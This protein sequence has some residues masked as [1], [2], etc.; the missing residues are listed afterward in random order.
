MMVQFASNLIQ[1]LK[2]F[3]DNLGPQYVLP[4]ELPESG[5]HPSIVCYVDHESFL[6]EQYKSMCVK[7]NGLSTRSKHIKTCLIT[8]CQPEEGKTTTC[9]NVAYSFAA[10]NKLSTVLID[11]DLRRP[12]IH[13]LW[14]IAEAPGLTDYLNGDIALDQLLAAPFVDGLHIIPAG[15]PV[16]DPSSLLSSPLLEEM[17][18]TLR[19]KYDRVIVDAPPV[20]RAADASTIGKLCDAVIF[21]V[22]AGA[23]PAN[24]IEEAFGV[25]AGTPAAPKA[26]ILTCASSSPDYFSYLTNQHYRRHF[27]GKYASYRKHY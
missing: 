22:R 7:I 6:N 20:L 11:A 5:V 24:M 12:K 9:C 1:G 27:Y 13:E 23:T 18:R 3:W 4:N 26:C 19:R 10:V 15:S 17:F 21:V 14:G 8:S 16:E 2:N 25:L